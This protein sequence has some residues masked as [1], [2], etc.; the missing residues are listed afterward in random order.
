MRMNGGVRKKVQNSI[1]EI[2][3]G[4]E[5]SLVSTLGAITGIAVGTGD[6][7]VVVLSGIVLI[8]AEA[9]SMAAGSYLSSKSSLEVYALRKRENKSRFLQNHVE[10]HDSMLALLQH[11]GLSETEIDAVH[12]A[13]EGEHMAF[14]KE[15]ERRE[16]RLAPS[17]APSP[18]ISAIVMGV[19][20]LAGGIFPIFPYAF[21]PV[22][23]AII[24]SII[25]TGVMLFGLGFWK[26]KVTKTDMLRSGLEMTSISLAAALIG[27]IVG[28]VASG[29]LVGI[30]V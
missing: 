5:D 3:F 21:L 7:F 29:L 2:V 6:T 8:F 27:Y 14:M 18:G 20:Y 13:L 26:G 12:E 1:R 28:R 10:G 24:P 25:L 17:L 15:L 4:M 23:E 11:K 22:A 19:F 30:A 9:L 16:A